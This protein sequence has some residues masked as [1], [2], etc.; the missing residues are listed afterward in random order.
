MIDLHTHLLPDWDDGPDNWNETAEMVEIAVNDGIDMICLTPHIFRFS[1]YQDSQEA[2]ESRFNEFNIKF[3]RDERIQFF[4]GGEMFIHPELVR[5]VRE[6]N[7]SINGSEYVFV[8][9]PEDQVPV[10]SKELFFRM[11]LSGLTPII[12]HPERNSALGNQPGLLYDLVCR[13]C[14]AQVTAGSLT[15]KFGDDIKQK[16]ELFLEN[17]LVHL[18]ASDAHDSKRRKPV[19]SQGVKAAAKIIGI[20]VAEAMVREVP[21]AILNNEIIPDLGS[22]ANPVSRKKFFGLFKK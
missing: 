13:G 2:L 8:E 11:M 20:E 5:E 3:G 18:I 22:P 9:F 1:R 7:L 10:G 19:L 21:K 17:R 15:G 4:R 16:A 12:S 14:L 6:R